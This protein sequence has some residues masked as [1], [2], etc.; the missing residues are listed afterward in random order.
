MGACAVATS[1]V[2]AGSTRPRGGLAEGPGRPRSVLGD[3]TGYTRH[4]AASASAAPRSDPVGFLATAYLHGSR[5]RRTRAAIA[6]T[7]PALAR[8]RD[9]EPA[10]SRSPRASCVTSSSSC[11]RGA[12]P[13][14]RSGPAPPW[15]ARIPR[16]PRPPA[17]RGGSRDAAEWSGSSRE[18]SVGEGSRA[19]AASDLSR[20]L[21]ITA[22]ALAGLLALAVVGLLIWS[23]RCAMAAEPETVAGCAGRSRGQRGAGPTTPARERGMVYPG[24]EA[25]AG[26]LTRRGCPGWWSGRHVTR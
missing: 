20:W 19:A 9:T 17:V 14:T 23:E 18:R 7:A 21:A 6:S 26:G 12:P 3:T 16:R 2:P 24:A 22:S 13:G 8:P 4:P 5:T 25:A 15:T 11:C 1:P 10:S